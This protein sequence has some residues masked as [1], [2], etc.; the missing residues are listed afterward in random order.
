MAA[1]NGARVAGAH[2]HG[3]GWHLAVSSAGNRGMI[4]HRLMTAIEGPTMV[5]DVQHRREAP[6]RRKEVFLTSELFSALRA[7]REKKTIVTLR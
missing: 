1:V 2:L 3:N 6:K 4:P 5:G 7:E